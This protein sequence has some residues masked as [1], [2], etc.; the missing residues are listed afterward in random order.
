LC[1]SVIVQLNNCAKE[2]IKITLANQKGGVGK[3]TI[4]FHLANIWAEEG[5]KVLCIDMDPQGNLSSSLWP[6]EIPEDSLISS[7]F[8]QKEPKTLERNGIYLVASDISLSVYEKDLSLKNYFRLKSWLDSAKDFD[9]AIIDC[10]PSLGL[11]TI[12]SLMASEWVI[13]PVDVSVYALRALGDLKN[14]LKELSE[15]E[16]PPSLLGI[17]LSSFT[18]YYR[19][20]KVI[21][22]HL[23]EKYKDILFSTIIPS[24]TKIREALMLGVPVWK[25]KGST[26]NVEKSFRLLAKEIIER[27]GIKRR[28]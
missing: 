10:P 19:A 15:I 4:A 24:S 6:E 25:V 2:M 27:I 22:E 1:Y 14:S 8:K 21:K 23:E 20:S 17:V 11:F 5:K 26:T 18:A 16:K 3:T 9:I 28:K 13:A 12:N 7:I